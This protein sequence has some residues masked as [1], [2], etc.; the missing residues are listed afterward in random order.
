MERILNSPILNFAGVLGCLALGVP[1][2][3]FFSAISLALGVFARS[4]K[5]GQYYH[6]PVFLIAM[7]L[8][9]WSLL[10]GAELTVG[11]A[12]IPVTGAMLM[13]QKLLSVSADPVPWGMLVPVLGG[14]A[15]S[16]ALALWWA[17]LQFR[18]ESV[19]FRE[20]GPAKRGSL[21]G[22]FKRTV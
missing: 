6:M 14:L 3:M 10:P 13:Q 7:T 8:A 17:V 2:A 21:F 1:L 19:L 11:R 16:I 12:L 9:T 22:V 20:M 15:A 5:E 4:T 18:R